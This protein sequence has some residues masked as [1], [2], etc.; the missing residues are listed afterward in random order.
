[1]LNFRAQRTGGVLL[2]VAGLL[3]CLH[4]SHARAQE[5]ARPSTTDE[6]KAGKTTQQERGVVFKIPDGYMPGPLSDF[7]GMVMLAQKAPAGM[8]V[9]HLSAGDTP[10]SI[11]QRLRATIVEMFVHKKEVPETAWQLKSLPPHEGDSGGWVATYADDELE[12]QVATYDRTEGQY[13]IVYGYFAGRSKKGAKGQFLDEQGKGVKDF[14]K[15]W[16]SLGDEKK[17][18]ARLTR[19]L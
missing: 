7:K 1:M 15:L 14:D 13:Q 18:N 9:S 5:E 10:D 8:F 19:D 11:R 16:K 3:L 4:T 2:L 12:V 17:K 6:V